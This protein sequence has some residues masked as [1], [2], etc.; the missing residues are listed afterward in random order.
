MTS[1]IG[2]H[3]PARI[4]LAKS[5]DQGTMGKQQRSI[6]AH[7]PRLS[8]PFKHEAQRYLPAGSPTQ[9]ATPK[10]LETLRSQTNLAE[11]L[12]TSITSRLD[13]LASGPT[14]KT[15]TSTSMDRRSRTIDKTSSSLILLLKSRATTH[16]PSNHQSQNGVQSL[17]ADTLRSA[18][19]RLL[20]ASHSIIARELR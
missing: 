13:R 12:P 7:S 10:R 11:F 3:T 20:T 15:T 5:A 9:F 8:K 1:L 14:D 17:N 6:R 18:S 16:G 4:N 2:N 19:G